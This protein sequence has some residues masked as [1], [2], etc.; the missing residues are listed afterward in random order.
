METLNTLEEAS[1]I[2]ALLP[3]LMRQL[4]TLD[5]R[6]LVNLPLAQL[7][8]CGTLLD[9]PCPM[10]FLS[11]ELGVSLSAMTQIADRLE[12]ANLVSRFVRHDDRRVRCLALTPHAEKLLR[13]LKDLRIRNVSAVLNYLSN[14]ARK[15]IIA[16]LE[17]FM[18]A[19]AAF[20]A[21]Q[22]LNGENTAGSPQKD[23]EKSL[24]KVSS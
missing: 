24:L 11:K 2:S 4:F 22:I 6:L 23:E 3:A 18:K 5:D 17:T 16:A 20:K 7:R 10:S 21:D 13:Q 15:E 1:Q 14:S 8:V 19:C 9:G 12:R